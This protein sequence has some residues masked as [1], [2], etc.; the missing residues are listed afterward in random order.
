M[1]TTE[2]LVLDLPSDLV[3]SIRGAIQRGDFSSE[4]EAV[5][6][7]LRTWSDEDLAESDAKTIRGLVAE[8]VAEIDAGHGIDADEVFDELEARYASRITAGER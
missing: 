3:A 6:I 4:S 8:A 5:S 1:T 7:I 2:R